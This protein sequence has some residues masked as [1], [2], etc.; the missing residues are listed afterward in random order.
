VQ[1]PSPGHSRPVRAD[2][3]THQPPSTPNTQRFLA[4]MNFTEECAT[5]MR[6]ETAADA[7]L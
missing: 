6:P 3:G 1:K 2:S 5:G 7:N 4:M